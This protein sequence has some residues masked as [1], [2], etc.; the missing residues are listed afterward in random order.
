MRCASIGLSL[1]GCLL[2]GLSASASPPVPP[3]YTLRPF[4]LEEPGTASPP[5][6]RDATPGPEDDASEPTSEP[7]GAAS[8]FEQAYRDYKAGKNASAAKALVAL[9]P[10]LDGERREAARY[11]LARALQAS[12]E[13]E[14]ALREVERLVDSKAYGAIAHKALGERAI[15][16]R[17]P[18]EAL[19]HLAAIPADHPA[20]VW[21]RLLTAKVQLAAGKL[22]EAGR[23]LDE[24]S[25]VARKDEHRAQILVYRG[26]LARRRAGGDSPGAAI[27]AWR[28]AF[29]LSL[30]PAGEAAEE[31]LVHAEAA[32]RALDHIERLLALGRHLGTD[33]L[34]KRLARIESRFR[35][36]VD[37]ALL[38]YAQGEVLRRA[39]ETRKAALAAFTKAANRSKDARLRARALY[40]A[41]F[42]LGKL[43]QLDDALE[44]LDAAVAAAPDAPS[45][46]SA[47]LRASVLAQEAERPLDAERLLETLIARHPD[48][49]ERLEGLWRLGLHR[50]LGGEYA[51][52]LPL[53]DEIAVRFGDRL[54][55]TRATWEERATYWRARTLDKLGRKPEAIAAFRQLVTRHPL[56]WYS[57]EALARLDEIAPD[58]A[59]SLRRPP[60]TIPDALASVLHLGAYQVARRPSMEEPIALLRLGLF[61]DARRALADRLAA[62]TL[63]Q[64]AVHLLAALQLRLGDPF[65]ALL[66]MRRHGHIADWP[67]EQTQRLWRLA[68]PTPFFAE[69][70][71]AA[72]ES[73]TPMALLYGVMRHE[74]GFRE[75][76]VSPVGAVG[77]IQLMIPTARELAKRIVG[78][79]PPGKADLMRAETNLRLGGAYLRELLSFYRGNLVLA[80]AA[81]NA[82][83]YAV[84]GWL[85]RFGHLDSDELV[86]VMPYRETADY[87]QLVIGSYRT[88]AHLYAAFEV[89]GAPSLAVPSRL[90]DSLGPF[91][92][93]V[94]DKRPERADDDASDGDDYEDEDDGGRKDRSAPAGDGAGG[95]APKG[96]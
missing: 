58:V 72:K 10:K 35:D 93:K 67:G 8:P 41:G 73:R 79:K 2:C 74:S 9:L 29:D 47:L 31:R 91:M 94:A 14:A 62:G 36:E 26:D 23:A 63:P 70:R 13:G 90:P 55:P 43:Q 76:A 85:K 50:Y 51:S 96:E 25:A 57:T 49:P 46:A 17:R 30:G 56:T 82:G 37:P 92:K 89:E 60:P 84:R 20:G 16:R 18:E 27:A 40:G 65:G 54:L 1:L 52:A 61:P 28:Q 75:D 80:V 45:A 33:A 87:T 12:G 5:R 48:A 68:F 53:L 81:Y 78:L 11:L 21:A 3:A 83:P 15:A 66:V 6:A 7:L 69:A 38:A 22:D 39:K 19:P 64:D 71:T 95:K 32:P 59:R 34:K 42:V 77:L 24:A 86:E 4:Y 44:R 88:Y